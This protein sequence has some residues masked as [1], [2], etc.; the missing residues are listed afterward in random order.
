MALG[1]QGTVAAIL[2]DFE[3]A[4]ISE[5]LKVAL[6]FLAKLVG[7]PAELTAADIEPLRAAGLSREEIEDAIQVC[8]VFSI[9][10]RL[11]DSFGWHVGREATFVQSAHFLLK[12]GYDL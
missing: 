8:G 4:A 9:I 1:N 5:K 11:A 12:R 10:N 2:A 7:S 6:R 3:T